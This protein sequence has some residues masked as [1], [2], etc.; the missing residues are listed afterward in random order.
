MSTINTIG[1]H[2]D[3]H[4]H[5]TPSTVSTNPF[6]RGSSTSPQLNNSALPTN[7]IDFQGEDPFSISSASQG[8]SSNSHSLNPT[9][10]QPTIAGGDVLPPPPAYVRVEQS[11]STTFPSTIAPAPGQTTAFT[12]ETPVI[13]IPASST[14]PS[15][16]TQIQT[17]PSWQPEPVNE[18][19]LKP[20]DWIDP[21]T[22]IEKRIK[23]ITQN[24]RHQILV[25]T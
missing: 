22:S 24:G 5:A 16:I 10:L 19:V 11:S 7:L 4:I 12:V 18:Y 20:I 23:I 25:K 9:I 13:A 15:E 14:T 1:S 8:A 3:Q 6:R 2:T 21:A 17:T